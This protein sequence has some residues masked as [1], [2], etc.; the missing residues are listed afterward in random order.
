M[1]VRL[2]TLTPL[3]TGGVD[4]VCD[5]L[6][7]TGLIGSLRWWYEALVRGLGGDACDP[8]THTCKYDPNTG[9]K[10]VCASCYLFG[11]TGWARKFRLKVSGHQR[12]SPEFGEIK[13]NSQQRRGWWLGAG[14]LSDEL[15]L[16]VLPMRP[17]GQPEL[18][19]LAFLINFVA[20]WAALGARTQ[21]G[22]GVIGLDTIALSGKV[23]STKEIIE[24]LTLIEHAARKHPAPDP[25]SRRLPDIRDFFFARLRLPPAIKEETLKLLG[26]PQYAEARKHGFVPS[27][28]HVRYEMRSWLRDPNFILKARRLDAL[29]HDLMGTIRRSAGLEA[30]R[31]SRLFVSHLYRIRDGWEFRIWGWVPDLSAYSV[32][33]DILLHKIRQK[34]EGTD[35]AKAV[36]GLDQ[37]LQLEWHTFDRQGSQSL[38][39]YLRNLSEGGGPNEL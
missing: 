13:V 10:S 8:T 24:G 26:E 34:L 5:R 16:T 18:K 1:E 30:P 2:R 35:F 36:F 6:H 33:R 32:Q 39:D 28:P 20:R 29:R 37:Q 15:T 27:A 17:T 38:A 4:Q 7:E 31:G 22:Y 25:V 21:M 11:T 19:S 23:F 3:W 12:R 14:V 9:P